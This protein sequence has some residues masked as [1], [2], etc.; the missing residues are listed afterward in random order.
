MAADKMPITPEV[1][2]WA[3]ERLGY[4]IAE[5][6]LKSSFGHIA[7][8]E[9]GRLK[10]TYRELEKLADKLKVPVAVFFFPEPPDFPPIEETFRTLGSEQFNEIPPKIRHLLYKAQGF[11]V[12]LSEL[13]DGRNPVAR[14]IVREMHLQVDEPI[15]AAA[16]SVRDFLAVTADEQFA[17]KSDRI[18]L[19]AWRQAFYGVGIYVFKDAFRDE[20]FCGFSLYDDE[21][22]IIYVNNSNTITRQIF[23]LFHELAHLIFHTSGVDKYGAFRNALPRDKQRVERSCNQLAAAILV[24]VREFEH[25][26]KRSHDLKADAEALSK[27]FRVS[28]EVIYH[29]FLDMKL[30]TQAEYNESAREW[31]KQRSKKK[32]G[33]G[34]Y[35]RTQISYLG[36]E[37]VSLAFRRFYQNRIDEEE[38]ADYLNVKPKNLDSLE[39]TFFGER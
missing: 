22:P 11:Q 26:W 8:W 30:V 18:A 1:V 16:A 15:H 33:G 38:L 7:E 19:D 10:P 29:R 13:N 27:R 32:G 9:S 4:S 28:R 37:Y 34:D 5:L 39:A 31:S 2:T 12:G 3:R 25:E 6:A 24:P 20:N 21:F 35:Y 17:W 36:D 23:T 14:K